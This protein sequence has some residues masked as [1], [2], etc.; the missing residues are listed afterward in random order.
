MNYVI[1]IPSY[2]RYE[3]LKN[4]TINYLKKQNIPIENIYIFVANKEE[5]DNYK[6]I[7]PE[8]NV[9]IGVIG[10]FNQRN[11]I[12]NY[13]D[14]ETYIISMDDDIEDIKQKL[15]DNKKDN[16][17]I[18]ID[19]KKFIFEAYEI[20]ISKKMY[21]WGI[22]MISNPFYAY[23][24]ISFDLRLCLGTFYGFI[25]RKK[26]IQINYPQVIGE[27]IVKTLQ[28]YIHDGG[29]V[30]FNDI[31]LDTKFYA[32]GGIQSLMNKQNR[33]EN[34]NQLITILIND[35]PQFV[36]RKKNGNYMFVKNPKNIL[37]LLIHR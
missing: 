7:F 22:N 18:S 26:M 36:K 1:A 10:L 11:F 20:L 37:N 21:L 28:Y 32:D 3:T 9:I 27:D 35:F 14:E 8:Y 6:K 2:N 19:L 15:T 13:F 25:N 12:C 33:I 30:R 31:I 16:K 23:K 29:V 34:L 17:L 24:K 4:K 5:F